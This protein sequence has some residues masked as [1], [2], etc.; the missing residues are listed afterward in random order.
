MSR[1]VVYE[2]E[3]S[4]DSGAVQLGGPASI[5]VVENGSDRFRSAKRRTHVA[6]E[7]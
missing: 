3:S 4:I 7:S 2:N 5:E 6:P 1:C